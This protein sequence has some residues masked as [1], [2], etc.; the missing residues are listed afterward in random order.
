MKDFAL[1]QLG[2]ESIVERHQFS[3][4]GSPTPSFAFGD[5]VFKYGGHIFAEKQPGQF[6]LGSIPYFVLHLFGLSYLNN[7]EIT[8]ALVSW[9]SASF[10]AALGAIA[11]FALCQRF[12][13]D[14]TWSL[15]VTLLYCFGTSLFVY[16]V[17]PHH[18]TIAASYLIIAFYF[19]YRLRHDPAP[20]KW[21]AV[22][23]GIMLGLTITTSML[24]LWPA[25][26]VCGYITFQKNWKM[27]SLTVL[28]GI[29]GL[30][31]LLYYD[32]ACFGNPL[33]LPNIAANASDTFLNPHPQYYIYKFALLFKW[34]LLYTP[35]TLV[36]I[37]S[38]ARLP[39]Q[40]RTEQLTIFA[41]ILLLVL[42]LLNIDT[43]GG[44]Q[45]GPRYLLPIM[46]LAML[47]L[48]VAATASRP[49]KIA[50]AIV[51]AYS[52]VVSLIGVLGGAMN[53]DVPHFAAPRY[54]QRLATER[55]PHFPLLI[56]L[57]PALAA[58]LPLLRRLRVRSITI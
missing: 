18:D 36:G 44:W 19:A 13:N 45:Y 16:A 32:Y 28:G 26:A 25:L 2:V 9:F 14:R 7:Y 47:G 40:F 50:I 8:A 48:A 11:L 38:A 10:I 39:K 51:A 33:L 27:L 22:G 37:A 57:V 49:V 41:A 24:A 30:L 53:G 52:V 29:I 4:E 55:L 42:Y 56:L 1:Q 12:S 6:M 54:L 46:P 35:I 17:L 21:L 20:N 43:M 15:V 31:P 3:L 5:D 58:A 23:V 34:I